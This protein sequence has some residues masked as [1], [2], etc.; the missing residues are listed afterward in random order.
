MTI[1]AEL[2]L[3]GKAAP[4]YRLV[5]ETYTKYLSR[6]FRELEQENYQLK[7]QLNKAP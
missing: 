2:I 5:N 6:K 3:S 1:K 7:Q 4:K